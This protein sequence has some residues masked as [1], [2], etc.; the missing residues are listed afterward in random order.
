MYFQHK[1]FV[2]E[3]KEKE[4]EVLFIGDLLVQELTVSKVRLNALLYCKILDLSTLKALA[5]DTIKRT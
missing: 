1:R 4:P 2:Q 5:G 3:T